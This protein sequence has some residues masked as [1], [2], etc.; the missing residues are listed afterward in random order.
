MPS[1][2]NLLERSSL[3]P[4]EEKEHLIANANAL[5]SGPHQEHV[6][7]GDGGH[8][9]D[10]LGVEHLDLGKAGARRPPPPRFCMGHEMG[11]NYEVY[12]NYE[13]F[14]CTGGS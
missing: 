7:D 11:D 8:G 14:L 10:P 5:L 12:E 13:A 6:I 2:A 4:I 1:L 3:T 9:V